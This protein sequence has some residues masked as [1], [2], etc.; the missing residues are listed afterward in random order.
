MLTSGKGAGL[1]LKLL[2]NP[3]HEAVHLEAANEPPG[4][5][6]LKEQVQVRGLSLKDVGGLIVHLDSPEA[7]EVGPPE[8]GAHR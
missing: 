8:G 4:A 1:S 5:L 7:V 6:V 2:I 3:V